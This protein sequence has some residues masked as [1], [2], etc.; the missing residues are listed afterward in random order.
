MFRTVA[1]SKN[2]RG[3]R[4][5]FVVL[6]GALLIA[7]YLGVGGAVASPGHATLRVPFQ[8]PTIQSAINAAHP[9]DTILVAP[10]TYFENLTIDK[11]ITLK[12]S[13]SGRTT[14]ECP[15]T[16]SGFV[17]TVAIVNGATVDLAGFTILNT[18]AND[19]AVL[20]V[21][22]S[23]ATIHDNS[24]QALGAGSTAIEISE[25]SSATITSNEIVATANPT[26]FG[27]IGIVVYAGSQTTITHNSITGPGAYGIWIVAST[28]TVEFN[29]ISQFE[30]G[31]NSGLVAAGLCGPNMALQFQ[32]AGI[33]DGNDPGLGTTIEYNLI[34]TTDAGV[35]LGEGCPGCVVK[36]NIV[37]NSADYGLAAFDGT[38]TF[39]QNTVIGGPYGV[40]AGAL[41][42]DTTVTLS[43]VLIV[44]PSVAPLYIESDFGYTAAIGGTWTVIG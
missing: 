39:L 30:C 14:I 15:A 13:G 2:V 4:G 6:V 26:D 35:F 1:V 8:Y 40:G 21:F 17:A 22:G 25:S 23:A 9:G 41:S 3:A 34:Y 36:G 11:S 10:G 44:D 28:A 19:W 29:S 31:Y 18:N 5:F 43:H 27:E 38:Y 16:P 32:G 20:V 33:F 42:V 24:I 7:G 37:V 12:G